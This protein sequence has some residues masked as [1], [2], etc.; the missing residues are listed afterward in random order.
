M[1]SFSGKYDIRLFANQRNDVDDYK[2]S[3]T[4]EWN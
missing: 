2:N 1:V 4:C 3:K